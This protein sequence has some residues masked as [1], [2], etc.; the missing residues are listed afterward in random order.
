MKYLEERKFETKYNE[1][2]W[3]LTVLEN[4][5]LSIRN[6][7]TLADARI[8]SISPDE[9]IEQIS[10]YEFLTISNSSK[11][12]GEE[13]EMVV[14]NLTVSEDEDMDVHYQ[15]FTHCYALTDNLLLLKNEKRG[16]CA[17]FS[18]RDGGNITA[19]D[20]LSKGYD[21]DAVNLSDD[22][23][24]DKIVLHV[25][26][27]IASDKANDYVQFVVDPVTFQ[28]IS[29]VHSTIRDKYMAVQSK[30][31]VETIIQEDSQY[32]KTVD[33]YSSEINNYSRDKAKE[34]LLSNNI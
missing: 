2:Q 24:E 32:K 29:K 19:F 26:K 31:D 16:S 9:I 13:R 34:K 7:A 1:E 28:P 20:W 15:R 25:T 14:L 6:K 23:N 4:N 17:V 22:V 5:Q 10:D 18:I 3:E 12:A 30:E 8:I 21:I 11:S 33:L 27:T